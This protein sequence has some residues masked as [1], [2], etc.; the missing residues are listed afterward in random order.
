MAQNNPKTTSL[1]GQAGQ[2]TQPLFGA[3][4]QQ[5]IQGVFVQNQQQQVPT[6]LFDMNQAAKT[7]L[8]SGQPTTSLFGTN[9]NLQSQ[10]AANIFGNQP[11]ASPAQQNS[12]F[13]NAEQPQSLF[14]AQ[15]QVQPSFFTQPQ[16][17]ATAQLSSPLFQTPQ[18]QALD[19]N[20]QI[21]LPQLLLSYAMNQPTSALSNFD[22]NNNP[23][24][25]LLSKLTTL[26]HQM[27]PTQNSSASPV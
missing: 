11:Q 20:L 8:F 4:P 1:F 9:Q 5:S 15:P 22:P 18:M 26:V 13:N 21:L 12:L 10:A 14:A 6:S 23:T 7:S 2:Q 27:N 3:N 17:V 25:D 19:P 24:M 16:Q